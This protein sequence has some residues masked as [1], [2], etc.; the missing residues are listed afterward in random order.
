MART[1]DLQVEYTTGLTKKVTADQRDYVVF[2]LAHQMS[3]FAGWRIMPNVTSRTLA[4]SVLKRENRLPRDKDGEPQS[5][6]DW[7][8]GVVEVADVDDEPEPEAAP[9]PTPSDQPLSD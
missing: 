3:V 8:A 1:I 6:E 7:S 9:D 5:F 4:H 2:E